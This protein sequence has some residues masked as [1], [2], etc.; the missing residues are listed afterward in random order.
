MALASFTP[1]DINYDYAIGGLPFTS[2]IG[3]RLGPYT[4]ADL[5][6]Q[7]APY[8]K[9]QVDQSANVGEQS[10]QF[11]W[12]RSQSSFHAGAGQK[13]LD[14]NGDSNAY[15]T[16]R[17]ERSRGVDVWT[18]GQVTLLPAMAQVDPGNNATS[19]KSRVV[20]GGS[21]TKSVY[22]TGYHG[23]VYG[24][25]QTD[26][27]GVWTAV[28]GHTG[29]VSGPLV[30]DGWT[31]YYTTS[32]GIWG[33]SSTAAGASAF[34][35]YATTLEPDL[36]FMKQRLMATVG[37][38]I[39]ELDQ[40]ATGATALP[41]AFY[42]HPNANL[43]WGGGGE[44]PTG[45]YFAANSRQTGTLYY[46]GI[47]SASGTPVLSAPIN[48]LTLPDGERFWDSDQCVGSYLG[49]FLGL[50]TS[51]GVRIAVINADG[52]VSLGALTL[53]EDPAAGEFW[54]GGF[55][56]HDRFLYAVCKGIDSVTQL[57]TGAEVCAFRI[58]LSVEVEPGRYAWAQD[59]CT[60]DAAFYPEACCWSPD[61]NFY[62]V[63]GSSPTCNMYRSCTN[64]GNVG[65]LPQ[66]QQDAYLLTSRIR[67]S[68]N[69][70]KVF[71]RV[72]ISGEGSVGSITATVT[73]NG[74]DAS[75]AA[76]VTLTGGGALQRAEARIDESFTGKKGP[77]VQVRLNV[78]GA[79]SANDDTIICHGYALKSL[80]GQK[81][82]RVQQIPLSC[83]D[84][85]R[86]QSGQRFGEGLTAWSRLKALEAL[87]ESGAVVRLQQFGPGF[88]SADDMNVVIDD[89]TFVQT[90]SP[91]SLNGWGG[92]VLVT[93][94][95]VD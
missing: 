70:D 8:R 46:V 81:R 77:F 95:T 63:G 64:S 62:I 93:V 87:E 38:K 60:A 65:G 88:T 68:M 54:F 30:T 89:V 85:E 32:T 83:F 29:T 1:T 55:A 58:D 18:P 84:D 14:G 86:D 49:K 3:A 94:R 69:D 24:V 11:W 12:L 40:N 16:L 47:T 25:W 42:T 36:Y 92:V 26:Y 74:T 10:L 71:E 80:P 4:I 72:Q 66:Y 6:R 82:Q 50:A 23:A 28:T 20:P 57:G 5:K 35:L 67:Y 56:A 59:F 9:E 7:T 15:R 37:N 90:G 27:M 53:A 44:G 48:V 13:F 45:M 79:A 21:F 39:Y 41:A 51:L 19:G 76:S 33:V 2:G 78:T 34:Q 91:S 52:S 73:L 43:K 31:V 75:A 22:T 61:L 17:F